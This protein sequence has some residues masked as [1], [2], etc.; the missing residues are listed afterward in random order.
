MQ[1]MYKYFHYSFITLGGHYSVYNW[2]T[3]QEE[4]S[5]LVRVDDVDGSCMVFESEAEQENA[6]TLVHDF[7][8]GLYEPAVALVM[9]RRYVCSPFTH[10]D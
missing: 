4:N 5:M 1:H 10:Y 6:M 2:L 7:K 9:Y 3:S 8:G